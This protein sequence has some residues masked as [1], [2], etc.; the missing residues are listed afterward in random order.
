MTL[1][2]LICAPVFLPYREVSRLEGALFVRMYGA[3]LAYLFLTR[4]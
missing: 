3:Y 2:A 4:I 1:V